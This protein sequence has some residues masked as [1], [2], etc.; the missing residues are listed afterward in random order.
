VAVAMILCWAVAVTAGRLTAYS[1]YVRT[2]TIVAVVIAAALMLIVRHVAARLFVG[3][4]VLAQPPERGPE[5]PALQ[6][7]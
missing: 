1:M 3:K 6:R 2:R 4:S 5:R 7:G